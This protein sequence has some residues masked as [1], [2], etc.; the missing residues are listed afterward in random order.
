MNGGGYGWERA[1]AR[2]PQRRSLALKTILWCQ[3][4]NGESHENNTGNSLISSK[5]LNK[6]TTLDG[7]TTAT[8]N[9]AKIAT[10]YEQSSETLQPKQEVAIVGKR[11]RLNQPLQSCGA[12]RNTLSGE[13][14]IIN[15]LSVELALRICVQHVI[16]NKQTK[17][18]CNAAKIRFLTVS[19]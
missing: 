13:F 9:H 11:W 14:F 15:P 12:I 8:N 18:L 4:R 6:D 3:P 7:A 19:M 5:K 10:F 2:R 16:K 17:N 1:R